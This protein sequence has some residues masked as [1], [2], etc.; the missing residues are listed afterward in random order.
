TNH[1]ENRPTPRPPWEIHEAGL[2]AISETA[3]AIEPLFYCPFVAGVSTR[4]PTLYLERSTCERGQHQPLQI[5]RRRR[6]PNLHRHHQQR[7]RTQ[8]RAQHI[9]R[10]VALRLNSRSRTLPQQARSSQEGKRT[11]PPLTSTLQQ[12]AQPRSSRAR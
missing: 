3:A 5:L 10:L 12:R 4:W 6:N 7:H 9:K 2:S 8:H 1:H 11:H